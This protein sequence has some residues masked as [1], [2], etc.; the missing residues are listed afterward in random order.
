MSPKE[1]AKILQQQRVKLERSALRSAKANAE[2]TGSKVREHIVRDDL[3]LEALSD[4]W[5][6]FKLSGGFKANHLWYTGE[7]LANF[8]VGQEGLSFVVGTNRPTKN[9]NFNLPELLE[10]RFPVWRLTLD[11]IERDLETNASEAMAAVIDGRGAR[12]KRQ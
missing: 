2:L 6:R 5:V 11:E 1:F 10:E 3:P 4:D 9:G 12:F 8:D 7:Y